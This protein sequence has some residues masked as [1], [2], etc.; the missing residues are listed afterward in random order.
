MADVS[1]VRSTGGEIYKGIQVTFTVPSG[2]AAG[3]FCAF[4]LGFDAGSP[5]DSKIEAGVS[6]GYRPDGYGICWRKFFNC[7]NDAEYE[8]IPLTIQ[9][10]AGDTMNIKLVN[11]GN[12][13]A[14]LYIN[15]YLAFT[16]TGY[17]GLPSLTT[18]KMC[19]TSGGATANQWTHAKF[20]SPQVR[21]W[22]GVWASWSSGYETYQTGNIVEHSWFPTLD[23]SLA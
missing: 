8:S 20:S 16:K 10:K 17:A 6:Y 4:Y 1:R 13:T 18:V 3:D 12:Q 7:R 9:P 22:D 23:T 19:H 21:S 14:S 5:L 15:G 11:N 2:L